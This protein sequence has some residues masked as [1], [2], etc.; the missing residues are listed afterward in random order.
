MTKKND[1]KLATELE[2]IL[3]A[4]KKNPKFLEHFR[5]I[6]SKGGKAP[7]ENC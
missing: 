5:R 1:Q 2:S 6:A 3:E 7:W 4:R